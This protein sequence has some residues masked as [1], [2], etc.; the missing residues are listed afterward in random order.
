M[1]MKI[2]VYIFRF[3][4]HPC[5]DIRWFRLSNDLPEEIWVQCDGL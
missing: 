4:G 5:H 3:P 1:I 2:C